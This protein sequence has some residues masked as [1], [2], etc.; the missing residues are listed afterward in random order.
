[1]FVIFQLK[2]C[3]IFSGFKIK[4]ESI[5][6]KRYSDSTINIALIFLLMISVMLSYFK[7]NYVIKIDK[8]MI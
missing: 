4:P 7:N 5:L 6:I 2:A 1:M 3:V 8:P